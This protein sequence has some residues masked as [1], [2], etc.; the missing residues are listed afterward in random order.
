MR[1]DDH[2]IFTA[3]L[4]GH[5]MRG[6]RRG[7]CKTKITFS[8]F[9]SENALRC[10]PPTGARKYIYDLNE[11]ACRTY[12]WVCVCVQPDHAWPARQSSHDRPF[13]WFEWNRFL[14]L[15]LRRIWICMFGLPT[16]LSFAGASSVRKPISRQNVIMSASHA[17]INICPLSKFIK[18]V[19]GQCEA[20]HCHVRRTLEWNEVWERALGGHFRW[21]DGSTTAVQICGSHRSHLVHWH[22]ACSIYTYIM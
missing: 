18:N 1:F 19:F 20:Q 8:C 16:I 12:V 17:P 5:S 6:G 3:R 21:S 4:V 7:R 22:G 14:L 2:H 10:G 11:M 9:Y 15:S 13:S